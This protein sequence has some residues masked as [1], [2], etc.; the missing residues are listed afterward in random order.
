ALAAVHADTYFINPARAQ[1]FLKAADGDPNK[2]MSMRETWMKSLVAKDPAKYGKY[3]K[4]W[5]SRNVDLRN[6]SMKLGGAQAVPVQVRSKQEYD[7]LPSGAHY[8]APDGSL[9]VK[10]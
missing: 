2:Y 1:Q 6:Y 5:S 7:R 3:D 10:S 4:A 9:R 8:Y